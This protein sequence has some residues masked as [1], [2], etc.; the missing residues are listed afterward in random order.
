M[1]VGCLLVVQL[2]LHFPSVGFPGEHRL[3]CEQ[4]E[5]LLTSGVSVW[6][7]PLDIDSVDPLLGVA[8]SVKPSSSW[9]NTMSI[10]E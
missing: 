2:S 1:T 4:G 3:L 7:R 5:T 10:C 8:E 6:L 9:L